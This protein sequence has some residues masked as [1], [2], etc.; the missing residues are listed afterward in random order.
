MLN[1]CER[2]TNRTKT[3]YRLPFDFGL[4]DNNVIIELDGPQHFIQV[5]NWKAP[6]KQQKRDKYKMEKA[7]ENGYTVIRLLQEDVFNDI[8]DWEDKLRTTLNKKFVTPTSSGY[9]AGKNKYACFD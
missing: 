3:N 6:K 1:D 9:I 4:V 8:S 7:N 2:L 5:M